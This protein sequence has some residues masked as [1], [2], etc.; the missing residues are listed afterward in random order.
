LF[1]KLTDNDNRN[2]LVEAFTGFFTIAIVRWLFPS[3]IPF[4]M[5]E[6]WHV[7][8]GSL[9][10]WLWTAWPIFAWGAGV[11]IIYAIFFRERDRW[12]AYDAEKLFG[13][14]MLVSLWA[15]V[16]EE[17]CFR[18]LIFLSGIVGIK[19]INFFFFGFLGFG[20]PHWFQLNVTG[21]VANFMT[22]GYLKDVLVN[23]NMWAVGASLLATNA[24]FRDGHKYQGW[25]GVVNSWFAGMFFF[26]LL[27]TYGLLAAIVVHFAYDALIDIVAYFTLVTERRFLWR[28]QPVA[29]R[30]FVR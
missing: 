10:D 2:Y 22:F 24:F 18:W 29:R 23:P 11:N 7:R 19:V 1:G 25:F 8:A 21:P 20:L 6:F 4:S 3:V 15:G 17:I 5:F 14:G 30:S 26:W 13:I 9:S 16:M 27:F 28:R 12:K